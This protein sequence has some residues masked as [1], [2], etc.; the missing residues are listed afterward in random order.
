[1]RK[2]S[3]G[4]RLIP[5]ILG[6]IL[7]IVV[8]LS[9]CVTASPPA[10]PTPPPPSEP[11]PAS[12]PAP[13]LELNPPQLISPANRATD[14]ELT[15]TLLWKEVPEAESYEL[16]VSLNYDFS[17]VVHSVSTRLTGYKIVEPLKPSTSYYW[18]ACA[19][20]NPADPNT[21]VSCSPVWMFTT[22]SK[23]LP[24]PYPT[25]APAPAP[26]PTPTPTPTP[27]QHLS[28]Q[29]LGQP[30]QM[31]QYVTPNDPEVKVVLNDI[32]SGEWRWAYNDFNALRE[33]VSMHV[34]YQS[35][36]DVH[37]VSE[38]WQLPAETRELG[39]GDCE[40]FAILLCTLLRAYGVPADQVYVIG[41]FPSEG[42]RGHAFLYEHWYK[43]IWR[44]IEPQVDP[45]T[46]ILAFEIVGWADVVT[47]TRDVWCFNDKFCFQGKPALPPGVHESWVD[48]SLWPA[49][50]GASVVFERHLNTGQKVSG[51][52]E[53]LPDRVWVKE[54]YQ[55]V[56]DWSLYI[57]APDGSTAL[58]WSGTD[59][60]HD[61]S[62]KPTASG[63][64]KIEILKR[65]YR[66]RGVRLT[67]DPPDWS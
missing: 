7:V 25:P 48:Y 11:I 61:F 20:L 34:S 65:D 50:R 40:D 58:S 52:V 24:A 23:P 59:L 66:A 64:Y 3:K 36:Q 9:G 62:F 35:D 13:L 28:R 37:G 33:W 51:S 46:D 2:Q 43:G 38:Y 8:G 17:D 12:T 29:P 10:S 26:M 18:F 27:T 22:T 45:I 32:L 6:I 44:A 21:T 15:P 31:K 63:T 49:T 1:M 67:I 4:T 47:Y 41:G 55:V 60:K 30:E 39:T 42:E 53:W 54:G 56:Y 5:I 19:K 16:K 57:Y 14:I